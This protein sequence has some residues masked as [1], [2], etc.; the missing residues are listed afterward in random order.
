MG[1]A[2]V[3]YQTSD[4]L[5][6]G[7]SISWMMC[8]LGQICFQSPEG[9]VFPVVLREWT[10]TKTGLKS[11]TIRGVDGALVK[12]RNLCKS[13]G[14]RVSPLTDEDTFKIVL[15]F[16]DL[17]NT[18]DW[19]QLEKSSG[20]HTNTFTLKTII[21]RC[22]D[23][24][25]KCPALEASGLSTVR[26]KLRSTDPDTPRSTHR[27]PTISVNLDNMIQTL[28]H[29]RRQVGNGVGAPEVEGQVPKG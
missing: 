23:T 11:Y 12:I 19:V 7:W 13:K 20:I 24:A 14:V 16:P 22:T 18:N 1:L 17:V 27:P 2:L 28:I 25:L 15:K 10:H 26:V 9:S 8:T 5:V 3:K 21:H 4:T 29:S 6:C